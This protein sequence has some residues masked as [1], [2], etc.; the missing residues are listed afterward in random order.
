MRSTRNPE[1]RRASVSLELIFALPILIG[2]VLAVIQ[3]S[4]LS[5][6]QH[7]LAQACREGCRMAALHYSEKEIRKG[8]RDYLGKGRLQ[9]AEIQVEIE[10][11][12]G[13]PICSGRPVAVRM[14]IPKGQAVPN[15]LAF[16][17]FGFGEEMLSAQSVMRKE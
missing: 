2:L 4:M 16:L 13:E 8:V 3:F 17:G 6:A 14:R 7:E 12:H 11:R 1:T 10:D 9:C 5:A 15:L